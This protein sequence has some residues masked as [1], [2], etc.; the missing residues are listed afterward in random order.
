MPFQ[1]SYEEAAQN[2]DIGRPNDQETFVDWIGS[3][4]I[5]L[6]KSLDMV[7]QRDILL[8]LN[9]LIFKAND[10]TAAPWDEFESDEAGGGGP[11]EPPTGTNPS[12]C[13]TKGGTGIWPQ[14]FCQ[15]IWDILSDEK[16]EEEKIEEETKAILKRLSS[17]LKNYDP[18]NEESV[19]NWIQT[20]ITGLPGS[21]VS[22]F[23]KDELIADLEFAVTQI[24]PQPDK[25]YF[26][27]NFQTL[28]FQNIYNPPPEDPEVTKLLEDIRKQQEKIARAKGRILDDEK[29]I[30]G[31][32]DFGFDTGFDTGETGFLEIHKPEISFNGVKALLEH[33]VKEKKIHFHH[34][35]KNYKRQFEKDLVNVIQTG[36]NKTL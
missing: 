22:N 14:V 27:S 19:R 4:I 26:Y 11:V 21:M 2:T 28:L 18:T 24:F 30:G 32:H 7:K 12:P 1:A 3:T 35:R 31:D 10:L 15:A 25:S 13:T 33:Y 34:H 29:R 6:E 17:S 20:T 5:D 9:D 23:K 8:K 36:V 16:E